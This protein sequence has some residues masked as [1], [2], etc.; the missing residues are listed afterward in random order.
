M[1]VERDADKRG[2]REHV[3]ATYTHGRWTEDP[4]LIPKYRE[5]LRLSVEGG[6]NSAEIARAMGIEGTERAVQRKARRWVRKGLEIWKPAGVDEMREIENAKLNDS[7]ARLLEVVR[8]PGLAYGSSGRPVIDPETGSP[9][10]NRHVIIAA[11][12]ALKSL[13]DRRANLN[14]LDVAVPV[15]VRVTA[16]PIVDAEIER[17]AAEL[18]AHGPGPRLELERGR[19]W[20]VT[21]DAEEAAAED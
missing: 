7:E 16:T 17:L 13:R 9:I 12:R 5:A 2:D 15:H 1:P 6:L 14:G 10:I 18:A 20:T 8:N 3:R 21:P 4:E 11:E 19:D